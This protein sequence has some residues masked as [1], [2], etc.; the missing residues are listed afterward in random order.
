MGGWSGFGFNRQRDLG[1]DVFYG[2]FDPCF[3]AL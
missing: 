3:E 1:R 2:G